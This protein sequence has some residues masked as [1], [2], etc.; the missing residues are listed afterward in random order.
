[1]WGLRLHAI[2]VLLLCKHP[3]LIIAGAQMLK[4]TLP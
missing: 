3:K 1:M 4:T 2:V